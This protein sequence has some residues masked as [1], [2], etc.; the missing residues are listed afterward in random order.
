M[1]KDAVRRYTDI[2]RTDPNALPPITLARAGN[3][4]ELIVVDGFHRLEAA[5]R[6]RRRDIRAVIVEG[7]TRAEV[8]WLAVEENVRNGVPIG[9]AERRAIFQRFVEAGKNRRP[10]GTLLTSRELV[11]SLQFASHQTFLT[12]M[13]ED[14]PDIHVEMG[15]RDLEDD[16]DQP[17]EGSRMEDQMTQNIEWAEGEYLRQIIKAADKLSKEKVAEIVGGIERRIGEALGVSDLQELLSN[18]AESDDF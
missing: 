10:D 15:G 8:R 7:H 13:K 1:S 6:A 11:R 3:G 14:F 2:Y 12:W 5:R 4:E 18:E 16:E 17:D 9:R